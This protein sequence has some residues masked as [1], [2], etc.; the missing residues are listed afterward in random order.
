MDFQKNLN[1]MLGIS[2]EVWERYNSERTKKLEA[3]SA[4]IDEIEKIIN[5]MTGI[6]HIENIRNMDDIR[7]WYIN[8]L[9]GLPDA[10]WAKYGPKN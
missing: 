5:K 4:K 9:M 6:T 8:T 3:I 1:W 7:Q 2:D 10:V